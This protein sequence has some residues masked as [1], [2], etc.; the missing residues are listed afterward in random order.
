[1]ITLR[2]HK[3]KGTTLSQAHSIRTNRSSLSQTHEQGILSLESHSPG[4]GCREKVARHD[5]HTKISD[6]GRLAPKLVLVQKWQALWFAGPVSENTNVVDVTKSR[7]QCK[8]LV[9]VVLQ[10]VQ[11]ITEM[12]KP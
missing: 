1:M 9:L 7:Y 6:Q 4:G 11:G 10:N 12:P 3:V 5:R 8:Q 2:P